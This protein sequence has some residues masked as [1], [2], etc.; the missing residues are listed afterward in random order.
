MRREGEKADT[1]PA[2]GRRRERRAECFTMVAFVDF[3]FCCKKICVKKVADAGKRYFPIIKDSHLSTITLN[4][5]STTS[6][7][8]LN[9]LEVAQMAT[10]Q[11]PKQCSMYLLGTW[12]TIKI[13]G[14]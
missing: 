9:A 8:H 11:S 5:P 7:W 14:S 3:V 6:T 13:D 12:I 1:R 10:S 2:V 4:Y